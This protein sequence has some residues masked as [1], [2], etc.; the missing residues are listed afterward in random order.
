MIALVGLGAGL[1]IKIAL[2]ARTPH[3]KESINQPMDQQAEDK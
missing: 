3:A 2:G 1:F